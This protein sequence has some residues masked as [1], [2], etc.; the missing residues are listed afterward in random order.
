M[1]HK[2][3]LPLQEAF[4]QEADQKEALKKL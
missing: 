2:Y 4:E 3:P 1:L